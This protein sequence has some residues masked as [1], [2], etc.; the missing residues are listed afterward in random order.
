MGLF[1]DD[2]SI[3]TILGEN[4]FLKSELKV[5]G[6]LR[7]YGDVDG[8]IESTGSVYIGE[9]ARIRGEV[10]AQSAEIFGIVLGNVNA[11]KSVRLSSTA[12]V[13]G[14]ICTRRVQIEE[15]A[16]FQ[17]H[18]ISLKDDEQFER[19]RENRENER[20][21]LFSIGSGGSSGRK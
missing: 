11:P 1:S 6:N 17:G 8:D 18:C 7:V 2:I 21:V 16:V 12:A 10:S 20:S 13:I 19:A 5:K 9:K 3:N 15:K 14:D 4:S